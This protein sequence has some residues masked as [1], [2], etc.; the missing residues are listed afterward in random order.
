MKCDSRRLF[1]PDYTIASLEV[2]F[3]RPLFQW[4]LTL[5]RVIVDSRHLHGSG[6]CDERFLGSLAG[7]R[8]QGVPNTQGILVEEVLGRCELYAVTE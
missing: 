2:V 6:S 1:A 4:A 7:A 8:G 5:E 3:S